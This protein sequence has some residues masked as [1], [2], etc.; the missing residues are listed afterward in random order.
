[1]IKNKILRKLIIG[2]SVFV[3][4]SLLAFF[5]WP[6]PYY[7]VVEP[8]IK[9]IM[10]FILYWRTLLI[11][12]CIILSFFIAIRYV[13][14]ILT[15]VLCR[16]WAYISLFFVCLKHRYKFKLLRIPFA[17][18]GGVK[19]KADILITKGEDTYKIHFIDIIFSYR[20][21]LLFEDGCRYVITPAYP[22]K[23]SRFGGDGTNVGGAYRGRRTMVL[24]SS[25]YYIDD[26]V[27]VDRPL[28]DF[29]KYTEAQHILMLQSV[30]VNAISKQ[31]KDSVTLTSDVEIGSAKFYFVKGFKRFLKR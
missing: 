2:F 3:I 19:D 29:A 8:L 7:F 18:L 6:L 31:R 12:A 10:F 9:F 22:G 14:P 27:E 11:L 30:P 1:M 28:P 15:F 13:I 21:V 26:N 5:T 17:S 24:R 4:L 25:G 20:R 16:I 23:P